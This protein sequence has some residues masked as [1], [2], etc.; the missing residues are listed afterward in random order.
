[1]L[2]VGKLYDED[3]WIQTTLDEVAP[4]VADTPRLKSTTSQN[5]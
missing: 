3:K 1:M 4:L 2:K 5:W